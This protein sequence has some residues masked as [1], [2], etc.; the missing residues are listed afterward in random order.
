METE[1]FSQNGQRSSLSLP[2]KCLWVRIASLSL[3]LQKQALTG[4]LGTSCSKEFF[5]K[6]P[7][8]PASVPKKDSILDV[9]L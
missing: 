7:E 8:R 4:S 5:A 1:P 9:L 6:V 3:K 2:T